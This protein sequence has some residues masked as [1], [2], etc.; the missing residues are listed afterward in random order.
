MD[1]VIRKDDWSPLYMI[2]CATP[3]GGSCC[4]LV[5]DSAWG[6]PLLIRLQ[7][8]CHL[9]SGMTAAGA[10]AY[11]ERQGFRVTRP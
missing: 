3:C 2:V 7:G 8:I 4:K 10:T 9:G 5:G 1:V 6:R 11:A